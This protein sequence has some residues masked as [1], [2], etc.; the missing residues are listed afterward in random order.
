MDDMYVSDEV[1][2]IRKKELSKM[3]KGIKEYCPFLDTVLHRH[4]KRMTME[5]NQALKELKKDPK[6]YNQLK[7]LLQAEFSPSVS[8][9]LS[10]STER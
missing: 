5:C 10:Q 7:S 8:L 4:A 3:E 1:K 9:F 6:S 2:E